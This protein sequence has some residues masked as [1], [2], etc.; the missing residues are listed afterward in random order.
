[1]KKAVLYAM[2]V[3]LA[4]ILFVPV[5]GRA[6]DLALFALLFVLAYVFHVMNDVVPVKDVEAALGTK[7]FFSI[8]CGMVKVN[9][10]K[11]ELVKGLL[12]IFSQTVLFYTREKASG[13]A[14]LMQTF[15]ADQVDTY[16][17]HKV[18]D[19]HQGVTFTLQGGDEVKFTSKHFQEREEEMRTALGWPGK[20][21]NEPDTAN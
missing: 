9:G 7:D 10:D 4:V 18:D 3:V 11:A 5:G 12:V 19:F 16:T 6:F 8:K 13:G 2:P 1:M 17:L 20:A 15:S 21:E 14:A